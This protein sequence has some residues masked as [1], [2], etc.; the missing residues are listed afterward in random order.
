MLR[1][2]EAEAYLFVVRKEEQS[3]PDVQINFASNET[4]TRGHL[5]TVPTSRPDQ[6]RGVS[7]EIA[8]LLEEFQDCLREE[9]PQELPPSRGYEHTID[10]GDA[11]PINLN[12]YPLSLVYLK[13]QS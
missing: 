7:A 8:Q 12:S 9:L 1:H 10:T 2:L 3:E 6:L 11:T 5:P 13:E 4:L